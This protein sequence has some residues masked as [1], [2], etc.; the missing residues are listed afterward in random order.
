VTNSGDP[1]ADLHELELGPIWESLQERYGSKIDPRASLTLDPRELGTEADVVL[2]ADVGVLEPVR[3]SGDCPSYE[4]RGVLGRG[5]M[6]EVSLARE[7]SLRRDV[8]LKRADAS[9]GAQRALL[10]EALLL[11]AL[12]H[13]NIVPVHRLASDEAGRPVL[14][15]KR[16]AGSSWQDLL[17]DPNHSTWS[18]LPPDPLAAN[19]QIFTQ[20]CSA[21]H[22]A[23]SRGV[24]HR[25]IKPNNVM[26]GEFGEVYLV[27]WG[28]GLRLEERAETPAGVV[29]TPA[30][31]AP[32]MLHEP[33]GLSRQTDVYLL[34]STLHQVLTG[35]PRH[36]GESPYNVLVRVLRSEPYDYGDGVPRELAELCNAATGRDPTQR[37]ESAA[38]L[39]RAVELFLEHRGSDDLAERASEKLAQLE[40]LYAGQGALEEASSEEAPALFAAA[41]FGFGQALE[42]WPENARAQAGLQRCLEATIEHELSQGRGALAKSLLADLPEARP[43]L[44]ARVSAQAEEEAGARARLTQLEAELDPTRGARTRAWAAAG[45]AIPVYGAAALLA[46]A[47]VT[48][49]LLFTYAVAAAF[50]TLVGALLAVHLWIGRAWLLATRPNRLVVGACAAGWGACVLNVAVCW[51]YE[52]YAWVMILNVGLILTMIAMQLALAVDRRLWVAAGLGAGACLSGLFLP[53]G[54]DPILVHVVT[55]LVVSLYVVAIWRKNGPGEV[56]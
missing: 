15:M 46:G 38:E 30:Y 31:M 14:V 17:E 24:L 6:G 19:L 54:S 2:E 42:I 43:E 47:V 52:I 1:T 56:T 41:R 49:R 18:S 25:D 45:L 55:G 27:D 12:E 13:P 50:T 16:I 3:L 10:R 44:A 21:V 36:S 39:R 8:A 53:A 35:T 26:V 28:L 32:E 48:K 29:G 11:G 40:E 34:G 33:L 23:H 9:D 51:A 37:P 20:V 5:G 7:R 4:P 22:Y